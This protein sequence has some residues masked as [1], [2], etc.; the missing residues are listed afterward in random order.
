VEEPPISPDAD[1]LGRET[2]AVVPGFRALD[3]LV[4]LFTINVL[5]F[6]LVS[7]VTKH[8][9]G[10]AWRHRTA[11][12]RQTVGL[13]PKTA[14]DSFAQPSPAAAPPLVQ[15]KFALRER[16]LEV[17][18]RAS[19]IGG[20][21]HRSADPHPSA[22]DR[23]RVQERASSPPGRSSEVL[24]PLGRPATLYELRQQAPVKA[25]MGASD[26]PFRVTAAGLSSEGNYDAGFTDY[27]E[28]VVAVHRP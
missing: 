25:K 15:A 20:V 26:R 18:D 8:H 2:N 10:G 16:D 6:V 7:A 13:E 23:N 4:I 5:V 22:G 9:G 21:S 27:S 12:S 19:S 3:L 17:A 11:S 28:S 14:A 1:P 24:E